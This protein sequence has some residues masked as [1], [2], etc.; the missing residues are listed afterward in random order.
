MLN[1]IPPLPPLKKIN[2]L[3]NIRANFSYVKHRHLI[4]ALLSNRYLS[5]TPCFNPD[6][7]SS[8][9]SRINVSYAIKGA[10][11]T[12]DIVEALMSVMEP[13][14]IKNGGWFSLSYEELLD[15]CI[16]CDSTLECS[17][18]PMKPPTTHISFKSFMVMTQL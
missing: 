5:N 14:L 3:G 12:A 18:L 15:T 10:G 6:Y 2:Y 11:H 16:Q 13:D 17:F 1:V 8:R 9:I 7:Y 4:A